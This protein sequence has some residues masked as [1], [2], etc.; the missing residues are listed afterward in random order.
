MINVLKC[1][2]SSNNDNFYN[3]KYTGYCMHIYMHTYPLKQP[4]RHISNC[5]VSASNSHKL[6]V[7]GNVI[8]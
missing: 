1:L 6:P 5:H 3:N 7:S 8:K 4:K 2:L